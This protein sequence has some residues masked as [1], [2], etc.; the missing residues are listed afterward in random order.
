M[1]SFEFILKH[2]SD[3]PQCSNLDRTARQEHIQYIEWAPEYASGEGDNPKRCI[4][5]GN[6]NDFSRRAVDLLEKA[7]YS[8]E[9]SDEW[10]TCCGCGCAM[11]TSRDSYD[12]QPNYI[13]TDSEV[14]CFEC[15][16]IPDYLL[17]IEDNPKSC[18]FERID[19]GEYGYVRISD[20]GEFEN[21]LRSGQN[22]KPE[23]ILKQLRHDG[24]SRILFR[25]PST[26]QFDIAFETWEAGPD[27]RDDED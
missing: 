9:W 4:L 7:G 15:A 1:P 11:R 13:M 19:P 12:W 27:L 6:W 21:G 18:C 26:G 14:L 2:D 23:D 5:M 16:D 10:T 25:V 22:D 20:P 24:H 17:S 8:I 3:E